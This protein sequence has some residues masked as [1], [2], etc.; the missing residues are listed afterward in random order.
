MRVQVCFDRLDQLWNADR[1]SEDWMSVDMEPALCL[2]FGDKRRE[3]NNRR[4]MQ[5]AIRL[6][7]FRYFT[8]VQPLHSYIEQNQIRLEPAGRLVGVGIMVFLQ[9]EIWTRSFEE[10]LNKMS[11]VWIVI[12]HQDA[13]FSFC[14]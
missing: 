6:D 5:F 10:D 9:H 2:G 7:L 4:I 14:R 12:D 1:L 13:S 3:K 8:S 11:V